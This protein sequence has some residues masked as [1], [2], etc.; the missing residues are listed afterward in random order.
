MGIFNIHCEA[1]LIWT[2]NRKCIGPSVKFNKFRSP[3]LM[4]FIILCSLC[5]CGYSYIFIQA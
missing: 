4:L 5:I 2:A 3:D 1:L